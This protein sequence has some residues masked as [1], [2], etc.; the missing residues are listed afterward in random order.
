MHNYIT[1]DVM[2][3]ADYILIAFVI[4]LVGGWLIGWNSRK[5]KK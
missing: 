2:W 4:G 5:I 1:I 3:I